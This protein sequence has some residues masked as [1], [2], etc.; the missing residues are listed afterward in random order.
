M[1][2]DP[3]YG[4]EQCFDLPKTA[5]LN[6]TNGDTVLARYKLSK[7]MTLNTMKLVAMTGG[8]EA[9]IRK[10]IVSKS[11]AGTGA[12]SALGTQALGTLANGDQV[13]LTLASALNADDV[14]IVSQLGTGAGAYVIQGQLF[15]QERFVQA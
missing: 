2:A 11:V 9:S 15:V 7:N 4:V 8:T 10:I 3:K 14:I 6:G 12:A 1:Y 5:A 13:S